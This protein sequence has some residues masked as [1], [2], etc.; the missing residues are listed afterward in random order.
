M[1]M[2]KNW[3]KEMR[4]RTRKKYKRQFR[5]QIILQLRKKTER[6]TKKV[7]LNRKQKTLRHNSLRLFSL[8]LPPQDSKGIQLNKLTLD[9][10]IRLLMARRERFDIKSFTTYRVILQIFERKL[11]KF[12]FTLYTLN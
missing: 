12:N 10:S 7:C 4:L 2:T 1:K 5:N 8:L 9:C 11:F 6:L 3:S